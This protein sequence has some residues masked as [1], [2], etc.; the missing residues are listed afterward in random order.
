MIPNHA[1][2]TLFVIIISI[3]S[4]CHFHYHFNVSVEQK[5]NRCMFF[6]HFMFVLLF[7]SEW[8]HMVKYWLS[9]GGVVF[10]FFYQPQRWF[11]SEWLSNIPWKFMNFSSILFPIRKSN[12]INT[13]HI[14]VML[15][16]VVINVV[17]LS[18]QNWNCHYCYKW[19]NLLTRICLVEKLFLVC[20][21]IFNIYDA[22]LHIVYNYANDDKM[23]HEDLTA[24]IWNGLFFEKPPFIHVVLTFPMNKTFLGFFFNRFA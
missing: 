7:H 11:A 18:K 13:Y 5:K 1:Q 10:L 6:G 23:Q 2:F 16:G 14:C 8:Q 22:L 20:R 17:I 19:I 4:L 9:G 3:V 15:M 21:L 12:T 24:Y